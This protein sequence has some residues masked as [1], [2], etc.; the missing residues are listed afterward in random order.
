MSGWLGR[1]GLAAVAGYV[2]GG[3][4]VAGLLASLGEGAAFF[5]GGRPVPGLWMFMASAAAL[6]VGTIFYV[7]GR[8]LVIAAAVESRAVLRRFSGG[9]VGAVVGTV[10]WFAGLVLAATVVLQAFASTVSPARPAGLAY[11]WSLVPSFLSRYLLVFFLFWAG[12]VLTY[13]SLSALTSEVNELLETDFLRTLSVAGVLACVLPL[14]EFVFW[15]LVLVG[16]R[17]LFKPE[18]VRVITVRVTK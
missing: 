16:A 18:A 17:N 13:A 10:V 4:G 8:L 14:A 5:G 3:V 9:A 12:N 15:V 11:L 6:A 1:A 2:F 7:V